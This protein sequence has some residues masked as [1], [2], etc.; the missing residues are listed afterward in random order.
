MFFE[1]KHAL[2]NVMNQINHLKILSK[3]K[4][5]VF[6]CQ[7]FFVGLIAP[8]IKSINTQ[9]LF[10]NFF[11]AFRDFAPLFYFVAKTDPKFDLSWKKNRKLVMIISRN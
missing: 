9:T 3:Q 2:D 6:C 5:G 1:L 11:E 10:D 7:H 4:N 8:N